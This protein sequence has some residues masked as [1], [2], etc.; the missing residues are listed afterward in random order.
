MTHRGPC[1][2]LP[3]CDSVGGRP[4]ASSGFGSCLERGKGPAAALERALGPLTSPLG[5]LP[6]QGGEGAPRALH[7]IQGCSQKPPGARG[8]LP[9]YGG[10]G[11]QGGGRGPVPADLPGAWGSPWGAVLPAHPARRR[12]SV[13][14]SGRADPGLKVVSP[15]RRY[16]RGIEPPGIAQNNGAAGNL[17][18][19][20]RSAGHVCVTVI[21]EVKMP[22]PLKTRLGLMCSGSLLVSRRWKEEG[23]VC[24]RESEALAGLQRRQPAE[25][26]ARAG[27][28]ASWKTDGKLWS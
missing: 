24:L 4:L 16:G 8:G 28:Q 26:D 7:R 5:Q 11:W 1:Q 3:C 20:R 18:A 13:P 19:Q 10:Q 15:Q 12:A 9:G 17:S 27:A 2:P 21:L 22:L 14:A 25:E 23:R 6:A